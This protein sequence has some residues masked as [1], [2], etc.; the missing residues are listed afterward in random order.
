M[1]A[2]LADTMDDA[3]SFFEGPRGRRWVLSRSR[4]WLGGVALV[5]LCA[6]LYLPGAFAMPTVDRDEA[7]FAQASRQMFESVALSE[8]ERDEALHGGGL[9]VPRFGAEDRLNT[10]PLVYWAQAG[11]AALFTGGDPSADAVWMYR[12]PSALFA[13]LAVLLT[14]RIGVGALDPRAGWLGAALLAACPVVVWEAHQARADQLLLA[15]TAGAMWG[16][17]RCASGRPGSR[18]GWAGAAVLWVSMGLGILAKGPIVV[19]V[20]GL[21]A[22]VLAMTRGWGVLLRVRPVTGVVILGAVLAP[23]A[24]LVA[25]RVGFDVLWAQLA[26]EAFGRAVSATEG[27]WW[28]PGYHLVLLAV[29]FWPGVLLAGL[30]VVRA[31][32][33][34]RPLA[35]VRW[36]AG[37]YSGAGAAGGAGVACGGGRRVGRRASRGDGVGVLAVADGRRGVGR[38]AAGGAWRVGGRDRGALGCDGGRVGAVGGRGVGLGA[39]FVA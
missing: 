28:P 8:G 23:W 37:R 31:W 19:L 34:A 27:R 21:A 6:A 22:V 14:W 5:V 30:G 1:R 20:V 2:W 38:G 35:V 3:R 24:V 7:R 11:S 39:A 16:L 29:L 15:C 26:G 13:A 32:R 36:G 33:R 4:G 12:V 17:W 10:P 18:F 9:V 25:Q